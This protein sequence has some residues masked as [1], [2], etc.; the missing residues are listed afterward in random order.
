MGDPKESVGE[1]TYEPDPAYLLAVSQADEYL[2]HH[3]GINKLGMDDDIVKAMLKSCGPALEVY[4]AMRKL[5]A[6]S[7]V[8]P[9]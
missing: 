1:E 5:C 7:L 6:S 3:D 8:S 9:R 4:R 2:A